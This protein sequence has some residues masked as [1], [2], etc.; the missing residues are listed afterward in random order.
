MVYF[1]I[2][3]VVVGLTHLPVTLI[4]SSDSGER[5]EL[6]KSI[7]DSARNERVQQGGCHPIKSSE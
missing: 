1:F 6:R 3:K 4:C 2:A 7:I 5:K